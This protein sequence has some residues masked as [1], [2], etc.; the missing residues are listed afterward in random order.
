MDVLEIDFYHCW[1][2]R[3]PWMRGRHHVKTVTATPRQLSPIRSEDSRTEVRI[4]RSRALHVSKT[5]RERSLDILTL[6]EE[7]RLKFH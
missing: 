7:A 5:L 4:R 2:P 6:L 1:L 3:R